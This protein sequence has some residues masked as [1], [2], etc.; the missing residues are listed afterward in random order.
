MSQ[1]RDSH[2]ATLLSPAMVSLRGR[3]TTGTPLSSAEMYDPAAGIVVAGL[4]PESGALLLTA[5]LLLTDVSWWR[6][7]I[8]CRSA[9][10][11]AELYDPATVRGR[12]PATMTE[13]RSLHTATLLPGGTVLWRAGTL[14]GPLPLAAAELYDPATGSWSQTASMSQKRYFF[15][16]RASGWQGARRGGVGNPAFLASAEALRPAT[17][18]WV[19]DRKP[20]GQSAQP[21]ADRHTAAQRH[22]VAAGGLG[23]ASCRCPSSELFH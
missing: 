9:V 14:E 11:G 12:R 3:G 16:P 2:T 17:G 7:T 8:R 22:S 15:T 19:A 20:S 18:T 10:F 21:A 5:T 4:E 6:R 23:R 13:V 1:A